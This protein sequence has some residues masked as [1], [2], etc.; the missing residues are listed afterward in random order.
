MVILANAADAIR[1]A[2]P[3]GVELRSVRG[4]VSYLPAE[5]F[6]SLRA[7]LLRGGMVIPPVRGQAMAGASFDIDDPDPSPRADSHAGNLERLARI[8]PGAEAGFDPSDLEGRVG[9]RAVAP[10]RLP[11]VGT[12]PGFDGL[13]GAFAYGSRGIL[14]CSLMAELL[15]SRLEGEPLPIEARLADAVAP[16]RFRLRAERRMSRGPR[17]A[18]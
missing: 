17:R 14:W 10:D 5:K 2:P 11:L 9:F 16:E 7:V 12:L 3:I 13:H 4:Q 15:A 1:L 18:R 8:L 6:P